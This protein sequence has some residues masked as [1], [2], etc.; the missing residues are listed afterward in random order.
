[1]SAG[2]APDPTLVLKFSF[3]PFRGAFIC[4]AVPQ[5]TAQPNSSTSRLYRPYSPDRP[6][7][8]ICIDHHHVA[9]RTGCGGAVFAQHPQ[10]PACGKRPFTVFAQQPCRS[11]K[12]VQRRRYANAPLRLRRTKFFSARSGSVACICN[13]STPMAASPQPRTEFTQPRSQIRKLLRP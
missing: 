10:M 6:L 9:P 5:C 2:C 4:V 7:K 11:T 3:L 13:R 1:M 12:V 8:A